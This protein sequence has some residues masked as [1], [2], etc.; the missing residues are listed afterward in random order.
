[1]LT[2]VVVLAASGYSST[3]RPLSSAYSLT[4]SMVMPFLAAVGLGAFFVEAAS[5]AAGFAAAPAAGFAAA[6]AGLVAAGGAVAAACAAASPGA[7]AS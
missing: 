7:N 4:P 6:A 5:D 1:M 2:V 3:F